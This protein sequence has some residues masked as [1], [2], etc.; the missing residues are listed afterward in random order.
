[1]QI[2]LLWDSIRPQ[3]ENQLPRKQMTADIGEYLEKEPLFSIGETDVATVELCG[4]YS[5]S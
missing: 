2:K 1:M 4:G 5:E 3:S